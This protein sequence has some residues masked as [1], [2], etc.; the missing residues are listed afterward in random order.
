MRAFI[1]SLALALAASFAAHAV[2]EIR[3]FDDPA[4]K[5]LYEELIAEL[6]CLVCQNQ[7]L[8]ASTA[9]LAGDL[10][11]ETY[12]MVEKGAS[13]QEIL[14]YMVARYGDFVLYRPPVK[15][16]TLL[17][18]IGPAALLCIGLVV[19]VMVARR[20]AAGTAKLADEERREARS[21]LED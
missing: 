15:S 4:K 10:R 2:V 3:H 14:D 13:E 16:T 1:L 20:R 11:Q 8:A 12:E 21:L 7:N 5:Q 18:W 9:D 6:R 19:V 17:L